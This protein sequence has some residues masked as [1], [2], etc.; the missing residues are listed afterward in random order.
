MIGSQLTDLL[1]NCM[2]YSP[3]EGNS[4]LANQHTFHVLS[5]PKFQDVSKNLPHVPVLSQISPIHVCHPVSWR[6]VLMLSTLPC[7]GLP[8]GLSIRVS[9]A[10]A[11]HI[12]FPQACY[13]AH[14]SH[15]LFD[16][17]NNIL[18]REEIMNLLIIYSSSFLCCY[19]CHTFRGFITCLCIVILCCLLFMKQRHIFSFLNIYS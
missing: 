12:S 3:C 8:N 14:I 5:N 9:R 2:Q 4:S 7:L 18:W 10:K 1:L 17:S 11:T 16:S 13:I 19:L 6:S 15:R